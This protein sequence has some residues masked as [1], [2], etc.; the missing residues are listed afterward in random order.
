MGKVTRSSAVEHREG[1]F[2]FKIKGAEET[3]GTFGT[4]IKFSCLSSETTEEGEAVTLSYFVGCKLSANEKCKLTNLMVACGMADSR[5]DACEF[6]NGGEGVD[7]EDFA[8]LFIGK[9]FEGRVDTKDN[10][11]PNIGAVRRVK[12]LVSTKLKP[13]PKLEDDDPFADE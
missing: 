5:E 9:R 1:W 13:K 8:A 4:Q 3:E 7:V 12:A 2:Q 10:G 6:D 11:Y